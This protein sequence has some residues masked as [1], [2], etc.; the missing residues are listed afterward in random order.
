[1]FSHLQ[2]RNRRERTLVGLADAVTM[3]VGWWSRRPPDQIRRVL[4]MRLE[5]IGDLLMTLDAI[6]LARQLL[7]DARI[8]LAVGSWNAELA[9]LLPGINRLE[10]M[11]VPWLARTGTG[12][13]WGALIAGARRWK[14][15]GY[16]LVLN[17]EPDIRSNFLSWL[18]GARRRAGYFTG[19]GGAFL[20]DSWA[21]APTEHVSTNASRLVYRALQVAD[22]DDKAGAV[23]RLHLAVP[24]EAHARADALVPADTRLV[25]VHASGG[26]PSKQWHPD[27]FGDAVRRIAERRGATVVLTGNASD[28]PLVDAVAARL[29]GTP[30]VDLCGR[31]DLTTLAAVLARLEL[32]VTG[33]TGPMHLAAAVGTPVVALFGP[34]D[35]RRYGPTGPSHQVLRIDLPCSPCGLVRMPPA[36]CRDRVPECLDRMTVEMVLEAADRI[37]PPNSSAGRQITV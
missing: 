3:P 33:D 5:R 16:D 4:L 34:S 25:G 22:D 23:A 17:F 7:P 36:H 21:Y 6:G 14:R 32:L 2:I 13:S 31:A 24:D 20:T 9:R 18:S 28:R 12:W 27:R 11:D 30:F 8:D 10:V 26:R 1:M 19:G 29:A 35:P 37:G 15:Q